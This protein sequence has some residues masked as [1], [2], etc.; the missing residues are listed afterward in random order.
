[1]ENDNEEQA[2]MIECNID[3][4]NPEIYESVMER[5]FNAGADDVFFQPIVMKKTRPAIK[6]SVLCKQSVIKQIKDILFTETSTLGVR[7]YDVK[8]TILERNWKIIET[9]WGNVKIKQ[10]ILIIKL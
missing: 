6:I 10:G 3:D 1:M 7:E 4:M 2:T 9:R 8:K 5:L